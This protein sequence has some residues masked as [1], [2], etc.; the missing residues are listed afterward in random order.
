MYAANTTVPIEKSQAE[1]KKILQRYGATSFAF[2]ENQETAIIAFELKSRR[3]KFNVPMPKPIPPANARQVAINKYEQLCRS[4]W[5][6][7][8]LAI[9]AKLECVDSGITTL[10]QEFLAHILLP[11]GQSFGEIY[12]PQIE[13]AYAGN[14][15]PP[16][17]GGAV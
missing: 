12:I 1:V 10:D 2:F 9:K 14:E 3:I 4:R 8:C 17:L 7:L 11:G 6:S 13:S 16:L 5:R 15:M